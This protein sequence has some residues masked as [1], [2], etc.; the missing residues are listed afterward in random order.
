MEQ[1]KVW[2]Q[3]KLPLATRGCCWAVLDGRWVGWGSGV[4]IETIYI[5]GSSFKRCRFV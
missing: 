1:V 2:D 5:A 4:Y 3:K